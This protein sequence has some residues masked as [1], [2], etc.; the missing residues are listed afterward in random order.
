MA[1]ENQFDPCWPSLLISPDLSVDEN[2]LSKPPGPRLQPLTPAAIRGCWLGQLQKHPETQ[3]EFFYFYFI[4][5]NVRRLLYN[6]AADWTSSAPLHLLFT[7]SFSGGG[8][9]S[10][11]LPT[12]CVKLLKS[13]QNSTFIEDFWGIKPAL[14]WFLRLKRKIKTTSVIDLNHLRRIIYSGM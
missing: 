11:C 3:A 13:R 14:V 6:Q 12:Q 1:F 4:S 10:V 2:V 7:S 5:L 8:H 9:S